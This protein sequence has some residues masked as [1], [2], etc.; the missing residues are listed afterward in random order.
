[1]LA[2]RLVEHFYTKRKLSIETLMGKVKPI[3]FEEFYCGFRNVCKLS[4]LQSEIVGILG[5]H[6]S[7][8]AH[9]FKKRLVKIRLS[10]VFQQGNTFVFEQLK[11]LVCLKGNS[12]REP[13]QCNFRNLVVIVPEN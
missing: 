2:G 3:V 12:R 8:F 7:Y 11:Y 6:S 1:M 5:K 9:F 13:F 10:K 4:S